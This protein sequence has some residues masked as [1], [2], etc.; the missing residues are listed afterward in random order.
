MA[1]QH[2]K[3]QCFRFPWYRNVNWIENQLL[4]A[5]P[6]GCVINIVVNHPRDVNV[7]GKLT[8]VVMF[9]ASLPSHLRSAMGPC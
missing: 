3:I 7:Q 5:I 9:C 2:S 8:H 6:S 4:N 1:I